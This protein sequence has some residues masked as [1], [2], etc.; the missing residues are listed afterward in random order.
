M[1]PIVV[2]LFKA[3]PPEEGVAPPVSSAAEPS[4][5][6]TTVSTIAVRAGDQATMVI[7]LLKVTLTF[8]PFNTKYLVRWVCPT[9]NR[10]NESEI[11]ICWYKSGRDQ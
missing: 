5:S 1:P 11:I 2:F 3:M 7:A 4:K 6:T 10:R 8:V 9:A